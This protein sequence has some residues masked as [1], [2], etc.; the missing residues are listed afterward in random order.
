MCH[1]QQGVN[2]AASWLWLLGWG[3]PLAGV[4]A[5]HDSAWHFPPS[6]TAA[7]LLLPAAWTV[8]ARAGGETRDK[9]F[10]FYAFYCRQIAPRVPLHCSAASLLG[11]FLTEVLFCT[12]VRRSDLIGITKNNEIFIWFAFA[13]HCIA[14]DRSPCCVVKPCCRKCTCLN[15]S[16]TFS[17]IQGAGVLHLKS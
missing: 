2:G 8:R 5:L 7:A 17:Q 10:Y 15:L 4:C 16:D 12:S 9:P 11:S 1:F 14:A 3:S 6:V 13:V